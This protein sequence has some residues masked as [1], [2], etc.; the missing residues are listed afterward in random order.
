VSAGLIALYPALGLGAI[1]LAAVLIVWRLG[2]GQSASRHRPASDTGRS[3]PDA[4]RPGR[5]CFDPA[6]RSCSGVG[7]TG[8]C[9][10]CRA[11]RRLIYWVIIPSTGL[12]QASFAPVLLDAVDQVAGGADLRVVELTLR[13]PVER[14]LEAR[15]V[16]IDH[17]TGR[18]SP[19]LILF[20]D[21]TAVK[22]AERL[23]ADFVANA[24]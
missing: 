4:A 12:W 17:D 22:R 20:H 8:S 13:V 6:A 24:T 3:G 15:L 14:H 11:R 10:R 5:G 23:R 18:R 7:C 9:G 19:L 21:M 1:L 16:R 2:L